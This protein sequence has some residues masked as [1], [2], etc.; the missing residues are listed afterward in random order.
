MKSTRRL[1]LSLL[2]AAS[3]TAGPVL[4]FPATADAA[5][6][7]LSCGAS[8]QDYSGTFTGI[9][10]QAP[11]DTITVAFTAPD[12][13][14]TSWHVEGW[15]GSGQGAYELLPGGV[16]W[17]DADSVS[18]PLTGVGSET[19]ASQDVTCAAGTTEVETLRGTIIAGAH[20]FSFSV[21][22]KN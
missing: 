2:C 3:C 16:Q 15:E 6:N 12:K 1:A 13:A 14:V 9:I 21:T 20:Q 10:D 22:R 18:G 17:D 19:Y 5:Q 7:Y 4:A 11:G 8:V